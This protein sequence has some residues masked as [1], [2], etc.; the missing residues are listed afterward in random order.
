MA[1]LALPPPVEGDGASNTKAGGAGIRRGSSGGATGA[2]GRGG[3]SVYGA[4]EEKSNV[5]SAPT[6]EGKKAKSRSQPNEKASHHAGGQY[7]KKPK[8]SKKERRE[9][10][11]RQRAAKA[12]KKG[13]GKQQSGS[14]K[15]QGKGG[16][17]KPRKTPATQSRF[18]CFHTWHLSLAG[19]PRGGISVF[20]R[21]TRSILSFVTLV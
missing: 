2:S 4:E 16:D 14:K 7:P 6:G 9:L 21:K 3:T 19:R 8:L 1:G 15:K 13:L 11:E 5:K 12:A 10:Q 18:P 20:R 17:T